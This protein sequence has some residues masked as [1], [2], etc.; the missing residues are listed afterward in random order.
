VAHQLG[1]AG[2]AARDR[3]AYQREREEYRDRGHSGK[4]RL[5]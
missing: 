5:K 4:L 2:S 3:A 1:T